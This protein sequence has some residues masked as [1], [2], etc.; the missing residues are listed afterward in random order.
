MRISFC[1]LI[2]L[3]F[4]IRGERYLGKGLSIK[5]I[6]HCISQ[7]IDENRGYTV[8]FPGNRW[9]ILG[10]PR[11][12]S[13]GQAEWEIANRIRILIDA[14]LICCGEDVELGAQYLCDF[15]GRDK[16]N[17]VLKTYGGLLNERVMLHRK[18]NITG[19]QVLHLKRLFTLLNNTSNNDLIQIPLSFYREAC[20]PRVRAIPWQITIYLII[21]LESIFL[22]GEYDKASVLAKRVADFL[23]QSSRYEETTY[24]EIFALYKCR[25]AIVHNGNQ[26]PV[27]Q[28]TEST[29]GTQFTFNHLD[30]NRSGYETLRRCFRKILEE[31]TTDKQIL[32]NSI[33]HWSGSLQ[34]S[35]LRH[36]ILTT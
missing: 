24:R 27:V 5:R 17:L 35:T 16:V 6:P 3:T 1:E 2:N 25:N 32:L 18:M 9:M 8:P 33:R 22:K 10:A 4:D 34:R 23:S 11:R 29:T 31:Q 7:V 19:R 28:I 20:V 14:L 30:L 36:N 15:D 12:D 21:S 26:S 13:I